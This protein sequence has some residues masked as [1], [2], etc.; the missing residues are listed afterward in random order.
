MTFGSPSRAR[1]FLGDKLGL[2]ALAIRLLS[3]RYSASALAV[4]LTG[5]LALTTAS[6]WRSS[7]GDKDNPD[8]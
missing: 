5:L 6:T 1:V 8:S 7:S 2:V 4:G 3:R